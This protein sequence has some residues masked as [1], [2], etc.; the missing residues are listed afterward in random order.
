MLYFGK[1]LLQVEVAADDGLEADVELGFADP[2]HPVLGDVRLGREFEA[3]FGGETVADGLQEDG[4]AVFL[5]PVDEDAGLACHAY[6]TLYLERH[7]H[8][9][10][11]VGVRTQDRR[12]VLY[13]KYERRRPLLINRVNNDFRQKLWPILVQ[14][15]V[16]GLHGLVLSRS[17]G[18]PH[19][20]EDLE[21]IIHPLYNLLLAIHEG[22]GLQLFKVDLTD[23]LELP[24]PLSSFVLPYLLL[25]VFFRWALPLLGLE[26]VLVELMRAHEEPD[27]QVVFV[28]GELVDLRL[29]FIVNA[30]VLVEVAAV[31]LKARLYFVI[32]ALYFFY[33]LLLE[34]HQ[35]VLHILLQFNEH[36]LSYLAASL[37]VPEGLVGLLQLPL[38]VSLH[39][40]FRRHFILTGKLPI[41]QR[42][43]GSHVWLLHDEAQQLLLLRCALF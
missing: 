42:L 35:F 3:D 26:V 2:L 19:L 30:L 38:D 33:D 40:L 17:R 15:Y 41:D 32:H 6:G 21:R 12:H 31:G 23:L 20:P 7:V 9:D 14:S 27:V 22:L 34:L 11:V 28:V 43:C 18:P 36:F 10:F 37:V 5:R 8:E 25:D 29:H 16:N 24:L 13:V 4:D 39:F 1:T